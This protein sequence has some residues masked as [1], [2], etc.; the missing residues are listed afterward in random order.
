MEPMIA[1]INLP[2]FGGAFHVWSI[3]MTFFQG[4][5]FL[6]YAYCHY[7]ARSI[8]KFHFILVLLALFWIPLQ[9]IFP[10]SNEISPGYLVLNLVLN[11]AIPFGVL[12][13][14]SVIAQSWFSYQYKNRKSPYQLYVTSNAGSL[15]ALIAYITIFEPMLGLQSQKIIWFGGFIV[16]VILA[17]KCQSQS[18]VESNRNTVSR[19]SKIQLKNAPI[20]LLLSALPSGFMLATTNAIT[21]ELGSMPLVWIIPLSIYLISFMISFSDK[22]I[23]S[24]R[25]LF[26]LLP[27]ALFFGLCSLYTVSIGA[28]WQLIAH[29]VALFFLS[30]TGHRELYNRRPEKE[31]LTQFYLIISVGGWLGGIFVSF[32]SPI[33]FNSL[34]EYPII[35]ALF[36]I[37]IIARRIKD[38]YNTLKYSPV[39]AI[40]GVIIFASIPFMVGLDKFRLSNENVIYQKRNFYGIY[41]VTERPLIHQVSIMGYTN[42][43]T[44]L[45]NDEA[46]LNIKTHEGTALDL[47]IKSGK[48]GIEDLLRKNGAKTSVE[49]LKTNFKNPRKEHLKQNPN[50]E[51]TPRFRALMHG[52]TYHGEQVLHPKYQRMAT[53]YYHANGP[54]GKIFKL[55]YEKPIKA[56]I[57]GLGIGTCATY[58]NENDSVVFYELDKEVEKIAKDHFTFLKNNKAKNAK[59]ITGDARIKIKKADNQIYDVIFVDA[60]SSD[61][62]P[63]HLLT[64][65][66]L[67]LYQA[68]LAPGGTIVFHISNRHYE[69][70]NVIHSTGKYNW[71]MFAYQTLSLQPFQDL[72]RFCALRRKG[73][74]VSD[75]LGSGW[76]SMEGLQNSMKAWTDD[77]INTLAPLYEKYRNE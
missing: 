73:E 68:K 51:E 61:A 55:E 13:T 25:L 14:T 33:T 44:Q 39:Y 32:I 70:L 6:G 60:F 56:A 42:F 58:F 19:N 11:Y 4:T 53:S 18:K 10:A 47:A 76:I 17:W 41:R 45:I 35:V 63:S 28:T 5:L 12:A 15:V 50:L 38:L 24:K 40:F 3:T 75:L 27:S 59:I 1:R 49:L 31:N 21:L 30:V 71:Q 74:S 8:G 16:Y 67:D 77:Y 26:F 2:N 62:I 66:A 65:E 48:S 34:L 9:T 54:M 52:S 72:A 36:V 29:I 23:I 43:V 64:K 69:L 37:A 46:N 7:V 22:L 20:W 57:I